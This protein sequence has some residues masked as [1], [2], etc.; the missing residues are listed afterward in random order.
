MPSI[1]DRDYPRPIII[2]GNPW[3]FYVVIAISIFLFLAFMIYL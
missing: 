2:P 1:L 3:P